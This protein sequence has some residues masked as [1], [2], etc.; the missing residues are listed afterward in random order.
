M[1][2][3]QV[4]AVVVIIIVVL[5]FESIGLTVIVD[6]DVEVDVW[7]CF[8][9]GCVVDKDFRLTSLCRIDYFFAIHAEGLIL[10]EIKLAGRNFGIEEVRA[11]AGMLRAGMIVVEL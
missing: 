10:A 2:W 4:G 1:G 11:K 5:T 9:H 8:P 6:G 7:A 3:G